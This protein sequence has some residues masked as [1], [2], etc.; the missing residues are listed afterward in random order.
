V[1]IVSKEDDSLG[2]ELSKKSAAA[3]LFVRFGKCRLSGV[4]GLADAKKA[5]SLRLRMPHTGMWDVIVFSP[6]I[7]R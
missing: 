5:P 1:H 2:S 4:S 3:F 6:A 7:S